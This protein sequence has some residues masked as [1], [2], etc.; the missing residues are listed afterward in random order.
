MVWLGGCRERE[1]NGGWGWGWMR[2]EGKEVG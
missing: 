1:R 2:V